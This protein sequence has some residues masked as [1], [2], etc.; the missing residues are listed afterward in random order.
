MLMALDN[1]DKK[2]IAEAIAIGI[3]NNSAQKQDHLN[4]VA[5]A[6][7][8]KDVEQLQKYLK[9]LWDWKKENEAVMT[10]A[11]NFMDTYRNTVRIVVAS[12]AITVI[13]LLIQ[14]YY[15]LSKSK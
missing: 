10:W 7:L 3:A 14:V 1:Q 9:L 4:E 13:G 12:G 5:F 2:D 11:R 6:K 8:S 15:T